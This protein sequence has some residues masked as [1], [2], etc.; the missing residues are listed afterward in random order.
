MDDVNEFLRR[1]V[2][3]PVP[4]RVI[5]LILSLVE[6]NVQLAELELDMLV[7]MIPRLRWRDIPRFGLFYMEDTDRFALLDRMDEI[8]LLIDLDTNEALAMLLGIRADPTALIR[9]YGHKQ[10]DEGGCMRC[11]RL[12]AGWLAWLFEL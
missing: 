1:H 4:H 10:H 11:M 2:D 5:Q 9:K 3:T 8:E 7:V 6:A 12:C